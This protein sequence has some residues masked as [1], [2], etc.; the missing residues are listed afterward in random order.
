MCF[1]PLS[2]S[3]RSF[4]FVLLYST[5]WNPFGKSCNT[6]PLWALKNVNYISFYCWPFCFSCRHYSV[7]LS[8]VVSSQQL[9]G[10]FPCPLALIHV[11]KIV[12]SLFRLVSSGLETKHI[13][14]NYFSFAV[15]WEG[16]LFPVGIA[17]KGFLTSWFI[18]HYF[19]CYFE[20]AT[21][22]FKPL[23][24]VFHTSK[25]MM[26]TV[27]LHSCHPAQRCKLYSEFFLTYLVL[28]SP[29]TWRLKLVWNTSL[30]TLCQLQIG[31]TE[32]D[33]CFWWHLLFFY[34]VFVFFFVMQQN[35]VK[36]LV[37]NVHGP[38]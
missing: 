8:S 17:V 10:I 25:W 27:G 36:A 20:R 23:H 29:V 35:S 19:I 7:F 38:G 2:V 26:W 14:H 34:I 30:N 31:W 21:L 24:R 5:L 16:C 18:M 3:V 6:F 28:S 33:R 22:R 15:P 32:D 13:R 37:K 4:Y 9:Q 11:L 12:N 1:I